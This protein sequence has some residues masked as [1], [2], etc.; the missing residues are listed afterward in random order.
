MWNR[1]QS[2]LKQD[3]INVPWLMEVLGDLYSYVP[4]QVCPGS[5]YTGGKK[6]HNYPNCAHAWI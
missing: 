6:V 2:V 3:L 5:N 4:V 1:G